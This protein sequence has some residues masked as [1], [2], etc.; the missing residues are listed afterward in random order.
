MRRGVMAA[1][2]LAMLGLGAA[3]AQAQ[4]R[5]AVDRPEIIE[6]GDP[7]LISRKT[8]AR[9]MTRNTD[10][11]A[12]V[13]LYGLP[14]YAEIQEIEIEPP[15]APYEV[16]LYYLK[17]N[18]YLAFGRVHVAPMLYDYGVRKYIGDIN[19]AELDRLLTAA[20][21]Y[22]LASAPETYPETAAPWI[23][24]TVAVEGRPVSDE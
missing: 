13:D 21:A 9:E 3:D 2:V 4:S 1:A 14:D 20:P 5:P 8:L 11:R 24:E 17:G 22:D 12:W 16:R 7:V 23:V 18:A 10:L 6:V 15:W 19:P